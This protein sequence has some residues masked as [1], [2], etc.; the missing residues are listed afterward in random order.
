MYAC[1]NTVGAAPTVHIMDN[2]AS[3]AFQRT[4]ATD[5]C[6]LQLVLPHVHRR[7]AAKRAIHT[8]KDHFLA[9]LAEKSMSFPANCWDL[10]IP[11]VEL[12]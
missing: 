8:F 11:Q 6:K 3:L 1:L 7:N 5:Q 12:T 4:V 2:E 10:L 9:I